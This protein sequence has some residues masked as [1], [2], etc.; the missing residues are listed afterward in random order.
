MDIL[1]T[2]AANF[3]ANILTLLIVNST[4]LIDNERKNMQKFTLAY[5]THSRLGAMLLFEN[6]CKGTYIF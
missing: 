3:H 4:Y 2:F 6:R 1:C 5:F